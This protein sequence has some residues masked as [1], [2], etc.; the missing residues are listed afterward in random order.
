M[1]LIYIV[2]QML[3]KTHHSNLYRNKSR[4]PIT[5]P[6]CKPSRLNMSVIKRNTKWLISSKATWKNVAKPRFDSTEKNWKS[7]A[8]EWPSCKRPTMNC[9]F[10]PTN[11]SLICILFMISSV[12]LTKIIEKLFLTVNLKKRNYWQFKVLILR[13]YDFKSLTAV[14]K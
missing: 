12:I 10:C 7:T 11:A 6:M 8:N 14:L 1:Y 2:L 5:A 13:M 9:S 4:K 3:F